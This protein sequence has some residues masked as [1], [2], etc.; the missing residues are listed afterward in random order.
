[1]T[2]EEFELEGWQFKTKNAYRQWYFIENLFIDAPWSPEHQI[3]AA[4]CIYDP[5]YGSIQIK[6]KLR[7][8]F[9][10]HTFYEGYCK[11]VKELNLIM[12]L[13]GLKDEVNKKR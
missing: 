8:D 4:E 13:I 3:L 12:N 5:I 10:F 1:M 2:K 7:S 6:C 11:D 9:E